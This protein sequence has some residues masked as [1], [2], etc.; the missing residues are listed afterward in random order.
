MASFNYEEW[1][2]KYHNEKFIDLFKYFSPEQKEL[3]KKFD[4][5]LEEK[6]YTEFEFDVIDEKLILFYK[7]E[8][9]MDEEQLKEC[10]ELPDG[11]DR[12]QFDELLA[13]MSKAREEYNF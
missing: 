3:L 4:I 2:E 5:T 8:E 12:A 6:L 9:E 7:N 1:N 10:E 11:I 13:V